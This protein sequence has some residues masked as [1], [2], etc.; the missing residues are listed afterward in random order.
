MREGC[1]SGVHVDVHFVAVR[2]LGGCGGE[3]KKC[4]LRLFVSKRCL[5][6]NWWGFVSE[7]F[8]WGEYVRF[9]MVCV[10]NENSMNYGMQ[11]DSE[12]A[13]QFFAVS[14]KG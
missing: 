13:L 5:L 10:G 7:G 11:S 12:S 3:F 2:V 6:M 4:R 1:G 14:E 8:C 9:I